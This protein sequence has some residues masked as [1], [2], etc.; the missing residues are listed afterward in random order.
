LEA[1]GHPKINKTR[2]PLTPAHFADFE[3]CFGADPN[4]LGRRRESD[5]SGDRWK[6]FSLDEIKKHRYKLDALK[7]L[8]DEELDDPD[9]MPE[10]EELITEALEALQLSL[11]DLADIQRLLEESGSPDV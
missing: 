3:H 9:E 7:W 8:R 2:H 10:P 5:S 6:R 1:A 4:G 11:D